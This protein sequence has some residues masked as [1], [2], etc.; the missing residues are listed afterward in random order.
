MIK[1]QKRIHRGLSLIQFFTTR[2][3][4]FESTEFMKIIDEMKG[5]D[6]EMYPMDFYALSEDEYMK[7][8][9][10]GGRQY[11]MKEDLSS[12]PRCRVQLKM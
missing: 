11:V 9:I 1:L 4:I 5:K 7:V 2:E 8:S 10:L 6:K 3:W 12:L